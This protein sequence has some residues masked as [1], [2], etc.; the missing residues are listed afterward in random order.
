[1]RKSREQAVVQTLLRSHQ[2]YLAALTIGAEVTYHITDARGKI[3]PIRYTG[4]A[5]TVLR[6]HKGMEPCSSSKQFG[7]DSSGP[8]HKHIFYRYDAMTAGDTCYTVLARLGS[9]AYGQVFKCENV[10]TRELVAIKVMSWDRRRTSERVFIR[11]QRILKT[12]SDI[13]ALHYKAIL[14]KYLEQLEEGDPQCEH[15]IIPLRGAFIYSKH[16]CLVFPAAGPSLYALLTK[17][18]YRGLDIHDVRN[19]TRQILD[20]LDYMHCKGLTHADLKPE[21]I[22][23]DRQALTSISWLYTWSNLF[24]FLSM[25]AKIR[26][27]YG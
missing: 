16:P 23:T 6:G 13:S 19:Y 27:V 3:L 4:E 5:L 8:H 11:E 26:S 15:H 12:V 1:M 18:L 2:Q 10:W 17:G 7:W 22:L 9:G 21:N 25:T 14:L 24:F 20:A